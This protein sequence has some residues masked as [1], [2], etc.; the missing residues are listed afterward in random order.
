MRLCVVLHKEI[1]GSSTLVQC[2]GI[3]GIAHVIGANSHL[4]A[5]I[6]NTAGFADADAQLGGRSVEVIGNTVGF[7]GQFIIVV[8]PEQILRHCGDNPVIGYFHR[9]G[10]DSV[11]LVGQG[12]VLLVG[13][14]CDH[15]V[16]I[17]FQSAGL[18]VDVVRFYGDGVAVIADLTGVNQLVAGLHAV[19]A[20]ACS[21]NIISDGNLAADGTGVSGVAEFGTGGVGNRYIVAVTGGSDIVFLG[22]ITAGGADMCSITL[23]GTSGGD[24]FCLIGVAKCR[25]ILSV[26][27]IAAGIAGIGGI[28]DGSAGSFGLMVNLVRML[29]H[30]DGGG[31]AVVTEGAGNGCV[32]DSGTGRIDGGGHEIVTGGGEKL[33]GG[34]TAIGAHGDDRTFFC[35][36]WVKVHC[37]KVVACSGQCFLISVS[38]DRTGMGGVSVFC[39][40]CFGDIAGIVVT[41]GGDGLGVGMAAG[42]GVNCGT[43]LGAGGSSGLAVVGVLVGLGSE[44]AGNSN[45]VGIGSVILAAGS[46]ILEYHG[47]CVKLHGSGNTQTTGSAAFTID[48]ACVH[49]GEVEGTGTAV[50]NADGAAVGNI[51]C[52]LVHGS[53]QRFGAMIVAPEEHNIHGVRDLCNGVIPGYGREIVTGSGMKRQ[54]AHNEQDLGLVH[55]CSGGLEGADRS[56][57]TGSASGGAHILIADVVD[58]VMITT[59][60]QT[61]VG[62]NVA[63]GIIMTPGI[64]DL[65]VIIQDTFNSGSHACGCAGNG[66]REGITDQTNGLVGYTGCVDCGQNRR[67]VSSDAMNVTEEDG[68]SLEVAGVCCQ[69]GNRH[70]REDQDDYEQC[71]QDSL[72]MLCQ[73]HDGFSFDVIFGC[74][75]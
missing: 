55:G 10:G 23:F 42:A 54:V 17:R 7:V 27:F 51:V 24:G 11:I 59:V 16:F 57:H 22:S 41:L 13:V 30:G 49:I 72:E 9:D 64:A 39:A 26:L 62:R 35:T 21:L 19:V 71:R 56:S 43:V 6:D 66:F 36:G 44:L 1:C 63:S 46:I 25:D 47:V 38:A 68:S 52:N 58:V 33:D 14:Q 5:A 73:F 45:V 40:G 15:I 37:G 4:A 67:H 74:C 61:G 34:N 12:V 60:Q 29:C 8:G 69:S 18:G 32:A 28:S 50:G 3:A 2:D 70:Q 53:R 48:V 65:D 20:V 75:S 31:F